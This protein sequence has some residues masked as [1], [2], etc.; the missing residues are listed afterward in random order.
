MNINLNFYLLL[1]TELAH[2]IAL[3]T[4]ILLVYSGLCILHPGGL[5]QSAGTDGSDF[6]NG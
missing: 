5:L 2:G 4:M 3:H 6:C 1:E